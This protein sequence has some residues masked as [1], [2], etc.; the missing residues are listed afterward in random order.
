MAETEETSE[1]EPSPVRK[2][3]RSQRQRVIA[4]VCGGVA[5]YFMI[6]VVVVRLLWVLFTLVGGSGILAYIICWIVIPDAQPGQ[7]MPA[8]AVGTGPLFVGI[9]L[10]IIG[11]ALLFTWSGVCGVAVPF[12]WP[13]FAFPGVIVVLALG[14]IIGWL[15][16]RSRV[17][18]TPPQAQG[19]PEQPPPTSSAARLY[20]SRN[21][22]VISGICGGLG[23]HFNIDP[24]IIRILWVLFAI[25][26]LGI[27]VLLYLI[28]IFVI[29][30]EP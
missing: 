7:E 29:P 21:F 26:S 24:T 11:A 12:C 15:L 2:I 13:S 5:E 1:S 20:R 3:H 27:A 18:P 10:V 14:L 9:F 19:D 8:A 16:S 22:K 25:T 28:L 6:D 30:E 4:G 17:N 23:L